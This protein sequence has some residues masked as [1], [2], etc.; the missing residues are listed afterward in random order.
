[1][2]IGNNT[3]YTAHFFCAQLFGFCFVVNSQVLFFDGFHLHGHH[4]GVVIKDE[5]IGRAEGINVGFILGL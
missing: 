5:N 1:M 3:F 4:I 2:Y